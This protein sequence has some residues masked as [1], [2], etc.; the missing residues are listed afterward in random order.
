[1][2]YLKDEKHVP[3]MK[4]WHQVI[5][6]FWNLFEW[7]P[8]DH[9]L[10]QRTASELAQAIVSPSLRD[11]FLMA[12]GDV[13]CDFPGR[14]FSLKSSKGGNCII[15]CNVEF[16]KRCIL[17]GTTSG[18]TRSKITPTTAHIQHNN[19][20]IA[21]DEENASTRFVLSIV[22]YHNWPP[23]NQRGEIRHVGGC[24]YLLC[25]QSTLSFFLPYPLTRNSNYLWQ[26]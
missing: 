24:G 22:F 8:G 25:V 16:M 6:Q 26:I 5:K 1:M 21:C 17:I 20:D 18:C 10:W 14:W 4:L 11:S 13:P 9:Y 19:W 2:F 23:K 3:K 12:C 7:K 15:R